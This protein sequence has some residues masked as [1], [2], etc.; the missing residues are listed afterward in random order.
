MPL[1][2]SQSVLHR[3]F[4]VRRG[5]EKWSTSEQWAKIISCRRKR[6]RNG[7]VLAAA[8]SSVG[9]RPPGKGD[10]LVANVHGVVVCV[11][12]A[13]CVCC[14]V[15]FPLPWHRN[16]QAAR[17]QAQRDVWTQTAHHHQ[18]HQN[19]RAPDTMHC[20][21]VGLISDGAADPRLLRRDGLQANTNS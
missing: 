9:A 13:A 11:V 17:G 12:V 19:T 15:P 14:P 5:W 4:L 21:P 18:P 10:F 8:S 1:R 6:G 7:V 20:A 16:D 3:K 2:D